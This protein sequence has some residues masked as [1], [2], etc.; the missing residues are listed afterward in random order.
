MVLDLRTLHA[1]REEHAAL[2]R[3]TESRTTVRRGRVV[4]L[5]Y[6]L[7][8]DGGAIVD[9]ACGSPPFAYLHG[10]GNIVPGLEQSLDGRVV[11]DRV[12]AV[13]PPELGYGRI[14]RGFIRKVAR[15]EFPTGARLERGMRFRSLVGDRT[16]LPAWIVDVGPREVTVSFNHPLAGETLHFA[17]AI[18]H[19]RTA[20]AEELSHGHPHG[21]G[22]VQ[23]DRPWLRARQHHGA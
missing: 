2:Q 12:H 17:V 13:V 8:T 7:R 11:G 10:A 23:H 15:T 1:Q 18:L 6:T 16:V 9:A 20:S 19:V 14:N 21:Y 5:H 22:G 3:M 4:S